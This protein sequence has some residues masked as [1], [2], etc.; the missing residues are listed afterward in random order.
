MAYNENWQCDVDYYTRLK[1]LSELC[2][3]SPEAVWYDL[4]KEALDM[5][6]VHSDKLREHLLSFEYF[7]RA[8]SL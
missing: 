2:K 1:Y 6:P 5:Y 8:A 3:A 4:S 7:D